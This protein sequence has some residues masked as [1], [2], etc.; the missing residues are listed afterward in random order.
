MPKNN[1]IKKLF[2]SF[3]LWLV[4]VSSLFFFFENKEIN[5]STLKSNLGDKLSVYYE[6]TEE[7]VK[8]PVLGI[9]NSVTLTPVP[10]RNEA[11]KVASSSNTQSNNIAK[12]TLPPV[13][14]S[15]DRTGVYSAINSYREK[16]GLAPVNINAKL[17]TSSMN[18]AK[19]MVDKNYFE[20]GNPW[21]FINGAGY[22]F[23]YASE[24]LAINYFSTDS[25]IKGW[26]NSPSHNKAMLDERNQDM[27]FSFICQVNVDTYSN[28]CLAVI[29]F[30]RA[31]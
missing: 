27:G 23:N 1:L 18:K 22:S 20:H 2:Y 14:V 8:S 24:N 19:D 7:A 25:L 11:R 28:T 5:E 6:S 4:I 10:T 9:Y 15:I 3:L 12:P 17:E 13:A 26:Q 16:S 30:A 31:N 21:Q 29:H